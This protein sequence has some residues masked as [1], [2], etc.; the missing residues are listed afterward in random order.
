ME[1]V[2]KAVRKEIEGV[3]LC[4]GT[5][6][7]HDSSRNFENGLTE[8]SESADLAMGE[9]GS[10]AKQPRV[11]RRRTRTRSRG[12]IITSEVI[13][14]DGV[15][16]E[17][18][19][20]GNVDLNCGPVEATTTLGLDLNRAFDL[21]TGLDLDLNLNE[22]LGLVNVSIDYEEGSRV[23]RRGFIDLNMDARCDL[24]PRKEGGGFDLNLE[25]NMDNNDIVQETNMQGQQE[26][27]E[28]KEVHVAEVSSVQ[29]FEEIG[30]QDV[31]SPQDLNTPE[32][33]GAEQDLDHDAKTPRLRRSARRALARFSS[34]SAITACLADEVSPS[35]SVSSLT[36]EKTWV[37]EGK[38][39]EDL[40]V[41][42]PKADTLLFL[43]P[44]E[45]E[46][47]VE[48]L[49]C[50]SPSLL[51]DSIHVSVLQILRKHLENLVA[52]GDPSAIAC[53]RSLDWDMLDVVNYPL[54]WSNTYCFLVLRTTLEWI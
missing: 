41:P 39:A 19:F 23:K 11:G 50:M 8:V 15:G 6:R 18:C 26:T 32:S 36:E 44:F 17:S 49:R 25:A 2:G 35:P 28:Y 43:S 31:V 54:L 42:P 4:S 38:A 47:F 14:D 29:L 24:S 16:E 20:G 46:D 27:E 53:L 10:Q 30:K 13:N 21:T 40:S 9:G 51:F 45:L 1:W 33:N 5:V 3:G 12:E 48:S 7:S 37:V 34:S 22:G 52:E